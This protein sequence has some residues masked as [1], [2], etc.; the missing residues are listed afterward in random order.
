M[1]KLETFIAKSHKIHGYK[2]DYS[3]VN[4]T[5][6]KEKVCIICHEHGEFWQTPDSHIQGHGCP[7]CN[8]SY[9][10]D[11]KNFIKKAEKIVKEKYSYRKV[12][13][14]NT[15]TPIIVTCK[16]HGDFSIKPEKL[17]AGQK[18]PLCSKESEHLLKVK[19]LQTFINEANKVHNEK[20]DYS[21]LIYKDNKKKVKII[22][23]IHG[24]FEQSPIKHLYGQGCPKCNSSKLENSMRDILANKHIKYIE[25]YNNLFLG[26]QR[27]DFYLPDY[28][29]GIE[30]QGEQHFI[31]VDFANNGE[32]WSKNLYIK[33]LKRDKIK[34]D[35]CNKNG[36][37]LLYFTSEKN[38][39]LINGNKFY[40]K[41]NLFIDENKLL[42]EIIKNS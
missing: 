22:C 29:V 37:K 25:Q 27:L 9:K 33:N 2:Y 6:C 12:N 41:N 8:K 40:N 35:K 24:E 5:N 18:C 11:T 31:P 21:K 32:E 3:K 42:E 34:N 10:L 4:Y 30:C 20:Y 38:S 1:N 39:K 23:P 28:K 7:K 16:K 15:I 19:T 36:I 26:L 17:L 13:Y 14:I